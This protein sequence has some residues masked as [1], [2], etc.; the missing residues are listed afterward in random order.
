M[1]MLD[2]GA[3][4]L[5][6]SYAWPHPLRLEMASCDSGAWWQISE[7]RVLFC[8]ELAQ[9]FAQLYRDYGQKWKPPS[10]EHWWQRLKWLGREAH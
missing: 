7:R 5:S 8:Y 3:G 2:T 6:E 9:E 1:K 4:H 10:K